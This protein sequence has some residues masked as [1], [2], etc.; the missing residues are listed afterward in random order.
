MGFQALE[1]LQGEL[2]GEN[3]VSGCKYTSALF[4]LGEFPQLDCILATRL[5]WSLCGCM[6]PKDV[7]LQVLSS[8]SSGL[9]QPWQQQLRL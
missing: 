9:I 7:D 6:S 8:E 4:R 1:P 2:Q 5:S 3:L